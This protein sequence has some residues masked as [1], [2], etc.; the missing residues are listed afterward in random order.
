MKLPGVIIPQNSPETPNQSPEGHQKPHLAHLIDS[1]D[2]RDDVRLEGI[3]SIFIISKIV[4]I[5][6]SQDQNILCNT[7]T[8]KGE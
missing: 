3:K 1:H 2:P 5:L 7:I 8:Y 6:K 4:I